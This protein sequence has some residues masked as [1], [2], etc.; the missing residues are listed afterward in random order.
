MY[1]IRTKGMSVAVQVI[2]DFPSLI[3]RLESLLLEL[4]QV[5]LRKFDRSLVSTLCGTRNLVDSLIVSRQNFLK[6]L[7]NMEP[8]PEELSRLGYLEIEAVPMEV[9]PVETVPKENSPSRGRRIRSES[10][11]GVVQQ[12]N[13][14]MADSERIFGETRNLINMV[15]SGDISSEC[16]SLTD[17]LLDEVRNNLFPRAQTLS[18]VFGGEAPKPQDLGGEASK[19]QAEGSRVQSLKA[20]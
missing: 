18:G 17:V 19:T 16:L 14:L 10:F 9:A 12:S 2:K 7:S 6:I 20:F 11:C 3:A 1:G 15:E 13:N 5:L 4:Q 8:T